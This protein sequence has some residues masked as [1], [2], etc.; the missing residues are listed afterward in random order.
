M[1]LPEPSSLVAV[2]VAQSSPVGSGK[3]IGPKPALQLPLVVTTVDPR[4]C[5][6]CP[7]PLGSHC[8][9]EKNSRRNI[10]LDT[11]SKPPVSV[12]IPLPYDAIVM[13]G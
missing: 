12:T 11:L 3:L 4:K 8:P 5:R 1:G 6:P 7:K 9:F 2:A 13:R 10:V